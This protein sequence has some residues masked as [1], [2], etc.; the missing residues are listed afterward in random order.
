MKRSYDSIS[1][2][3]GYTFE[4]VFRLYY[5]R[6]RFFAYQMLH[7]IDLAEDVVQEAFIVYWKERKGLSTHDKVVKSFLYSTMKFIAL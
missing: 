5:K 3:V 7:D 6:V 2:D 4:D 1:L